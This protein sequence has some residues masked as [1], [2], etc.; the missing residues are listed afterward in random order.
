[1]LFF[2]SCSFSVVYLSDQNN[3]EM[4]NYAGVYCVLFNTHFAHAYFLF[5]HEAT[6]GVMDKPKLAKVSF[7][8]VYF[9]YLCIVKV[10]YVDVCLIITMLIS[11]HRW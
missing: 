9:L 5:E 8:C 7:G 3:F 6:I 10:F 4:V 2:V 1:M 11:H